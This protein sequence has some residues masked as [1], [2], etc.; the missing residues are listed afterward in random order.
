MISEKGSLRANNKIYSSSPSDS[1]PARPEIS[2]VHVDEIAFKQ[3]CPTNAIGVTPIRI[4]LGKCNFCKTCAR[5]F[6]DKVVFTRDH[7]VSSNV[8]D[9]LIILEGDHGQ[10]TLASDVG[11]NIKKEFIANVF[12]AG[13]DFTGLNEVRDAGIRTSASARDANTVIIGVPL[14]DDELIDIYQQL[15]EPK[16]LILAGSNVLQEDM[17]SRAFF[18]HHPPDL[19]IPGDPVH[20]I[21]IAL[22]LESLIR[23]NE[24]IETI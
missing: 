5:E 18:E 8:R 13:T 23:L 16:I 19:F 24:K 21:T 12:F 22:G 7:H 2:L 14:R 3:C 4:D 20:A 9:R 11:R 15:L 10:I 17:M 6:P 1:I